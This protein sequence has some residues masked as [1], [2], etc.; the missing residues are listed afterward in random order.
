MPFLAGEIVTAERLNLLQPKTY[1][2]RAT[3]LLDGAGTGL[4]VPGATVTFDSFTDNARV[5]VEVSTAIG[6]DGVGTGR[7]DVIVN[8]D[9]V[10]TLPRASFGQGPGNASDVVTAAAVVNESLG[11]AGSHTIHLTANLASYQL[12]NVY[13]ALNVTVYEIV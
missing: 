4:V 8:I 7:A 2:A 11:A 10:G 12:V 1:F 5:V 3:T 13:T 9:G 6:F